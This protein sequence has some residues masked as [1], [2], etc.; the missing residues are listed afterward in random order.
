MRT[1]HFVLFSGE[2][3][4]PELQ[5]EVRAGRVLHFSPEDLYR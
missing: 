5:A 3:L 2:E 4:P 1:I